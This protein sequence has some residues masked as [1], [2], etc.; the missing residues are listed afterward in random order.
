[1]TLCLNKVM[2]IGILGRDPEMR[3]TPNGQSVSSFSIGCNR[4]SSTLEGE[5][6]VETDWYHVVVWGDLAETVHQT[7]YEGCLAFVEG[8]LQTRIWRDEHGNQKKSVEIVAQQVMLL[9]GHHK[10]TKIESMDR[11]GNS[12]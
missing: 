6:Q 5:R 1:M 12:F 7:L 3:F 2:I 11:K 9:E 8:R 4:P 10:K